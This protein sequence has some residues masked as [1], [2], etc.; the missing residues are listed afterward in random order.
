[1][2][3]VADYGIPSIHMGLEVA[4]LEKA[5]KLIFQAAKPTTEAEKP[6]LGGMILFSPDGVHPYTD[7]GH[8]LYLEAI[9]RSVPL[10][11][12]AGEV[13]PHALV[14]PMVPDNWE[15]AKML[16]L[17]RAKLSGQWQLL[18]PLTNSLAKAFGGRRPES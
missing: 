2:P 14:E 7:S 6:A 4:R 17:S 10:I 9:A 12:K 1:M 18:D 3:E 8:Q 5:H 16:P 15:A 13:G 11:E